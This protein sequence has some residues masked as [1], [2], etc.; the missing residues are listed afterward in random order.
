MPE[1]VKRYRTISADE[2]ISGTLATDDD[3]EI[4]L[5]ADHARIVAA[6]EAEN[7]ALKLQVG[8]LSAPGMERSASQPDWLPE[9]AASAPGGRL[10]SRARNCLIVLWQG[11]WQKPPR[12][13]SIPRSLEDICAWT[14][15]DLLCLKNCGLK[16]AHELERAINAA[17]TTPPQER[18]H[19]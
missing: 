5:Y 6:L 15:N 16:T 11:R 12:G 17:R 14:L 19:R 9:F 10:S 8:R 3:G 2:M 13:K 1:Q 7:A 4:V 18:A